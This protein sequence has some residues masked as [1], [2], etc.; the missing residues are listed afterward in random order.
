MEL[1][2]TLEL[3]PNGIFRVGSNPTTITNGEVAE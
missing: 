1:V 2:Y 3:D